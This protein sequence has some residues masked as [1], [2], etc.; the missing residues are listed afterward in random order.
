MFKSDSKEEHHLRIHLSLKFDVVDLFPT[1]VILQVYMA[2]ATIS[3]F[4]QVKCH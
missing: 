3:T 4:G 1:L 2:L